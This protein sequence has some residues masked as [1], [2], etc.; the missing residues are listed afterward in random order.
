M[1]S[2]HAS[3]VKDGKSSIHGSLDCMVFPFG[4]TTWMGSPRFVDGRC[5]ASACK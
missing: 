3:S 4:N 1:W 5:G 2:S